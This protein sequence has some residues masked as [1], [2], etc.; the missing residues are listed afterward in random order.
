MGKKGWVAKIRYFMKGG[1]SSAQDLVE[2]ILQ[3]GEG[4]GNVGGSFISRMGKGLGGIPENDHGNVVLHV[5]PGKLG[6]KFDD[7]IVYDL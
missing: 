4:D 5:L 2:L 1:R 3:F 7:F 6:L